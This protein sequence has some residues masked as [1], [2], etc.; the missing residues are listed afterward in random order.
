MSWVSR[1]RPRSFK[2]VLDQKEAIETLMAWY[3]NW[4]PGSKAMLLYGPPGCG[5]TVIVEALAQEEGL[6]LIEMNASDFRSAEAIEARIG[7]SMA[8]ASIF[9]RPKLFLIDEVDGLAGEEDRGGVG[10]II[11]IIKGSKHP[12]VLTANDPYN[13]RL[14]TIR[15]YCQLVRMRRLGIRDVQRYLERIAELEGLSIDESVL[16]IIAS[17]SQGDLRSAI[18]DL[19]VLGR[20]SRIIR[21]EDLSSLGFRERQTDIFEA[22]Q[23]IFKTKSL[24][25]AKLSLNEVDKDLEEV[26]WWI[27]NNIA[28]EYE[29]PLEIAKAFDAL[30]K[31]DLFM[32]RVIF[33][34]NWK[35]QAY[36]VDL[37]TGGV[38]LA[39][40]EPYR[41]FTRYTYPSNIALLGRTKGE[42]SEAL[43]ALGKLG[44]ILHCSRRKV[45]AEFL[46]YLKIMAKRPDFKERLDA[47][48]EASED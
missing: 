13:E 7:R 19:E 14:R 38:A 35:L 4:K 25:T 39:K 28:E 34:Q 5:K 21:D 47:F 11:Q 6:D 12:I 15:P 37:M 33:R 45:R 31:A 8:Q 18:N 48:M 32:S 43:K 22:L 46:P 29:D 42:R 40:R 16:K 20:G 23:A 36:A 1:Y 17:R 41:K 30:S 3:K 9:Q 26:F 27:E 24:M 44:S 2:E 10:A